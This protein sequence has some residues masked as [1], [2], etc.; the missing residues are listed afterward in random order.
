MEV[1]NI[2]TAL[3]EKIKELELNFDKDEKEIDY[4]NKVREEMAEPDSF[5]KYIKD[6]EKIQIKLDEIIEKLNEKLS[7]NKIYCSQSK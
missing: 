3:R 5:E 6:L 1:E 4:E 2:L 7:D